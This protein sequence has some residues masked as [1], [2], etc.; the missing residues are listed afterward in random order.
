[1]KHELNSISEPFN[2]DVPNKASLHI[3]FCILTK[4]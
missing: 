2:I 4:A 3:A 1:M